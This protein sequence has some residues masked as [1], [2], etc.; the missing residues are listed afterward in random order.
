MCVGGGAGAVTGVVKLETERGSRTGRPQTVGPVLRKCTCQ[1][2][3][4]TQAKVQLER[5]L[6]EVWYMVGVKNRIWCQ[7]KSEFV[8]L[9]SYLPQT[10]E[11]SVGLGGAL[12]DTGENERPRGQIFPEDSSCSRKAPPQG[13]RHAFRGLGARSWLGQP[14]RLGWCK[15]AMTDFFHFFRAPERKLWPR[16]PQETSLS[17][18]FRLCY[19]EWGGQ[20]GKNTVIRPRSSSQDV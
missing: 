11:A 3:A 19:W 8:L 10:C 13:P 14:P 20:W 6:E 15:G 18:V 17:C 2:K 16:T 5:N 1:K 4:F 12:G 7:Q 9:S